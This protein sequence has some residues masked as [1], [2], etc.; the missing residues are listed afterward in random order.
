[1][2]QCPFAFPLLFLDPFLMPI[3][4]HNLGLSMEQLE[5]FRRI[6]FPRTPLLPA[7]SSYLTHCSPPRRSPRLS[8]QDGDS[9][10]TPIGSAVAMHSISERER[11][12]GRGR[13]RE[14]IFKS[15]LG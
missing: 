9:T 6:I 12:K 10:T 2:K 5:V 11:E 8:F 13:T 1:M 15:N 14:E 4:M 3:G 7:P